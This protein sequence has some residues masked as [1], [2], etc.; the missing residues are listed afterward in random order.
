[1]VQQVMPSHGYLGIIFFQIEPIVRHFQTTPRT[2]LQLIGPFA[3]NTFDYIGAM[4]HRDEFP[5]T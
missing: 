2:I 3:E 4:L 1:M 5:R